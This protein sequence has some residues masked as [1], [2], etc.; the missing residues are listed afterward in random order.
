MVQGYPVIAVPN[1]KISALG[2]N[3]NYSL[4]VL[5]CNSKGALELRN[6]WGTITERSNISLS[7][8]G[9]FELSSSYTNDYISHIMIAYTDP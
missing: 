4:S 5:K 3:P 9:V 2:L 8:E 6:S 7:K 1:S